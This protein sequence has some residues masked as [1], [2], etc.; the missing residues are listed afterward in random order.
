[1]EENACFKCRFGSILIDIRVPGNYDAER[2]GREIKKYAEKLAEII[3]QKQIHYA[4]TFDAQQHHLNV[5]LSCTF[6]L[7]IKKQ[8]CS[9]YNLTAH[10]RV[11]HLN[12]NERLPLLEESPQL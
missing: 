7:N 3:N 9:N 2:F 11:K 1:M 6:I 8:D 5:N 12:R 10:L 4:L